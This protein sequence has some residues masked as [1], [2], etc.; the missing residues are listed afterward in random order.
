MDDAADSALI[1]LGWNA[2]LAA[3]WQL[4]GAPGEPRRVV[5]LDRGWSSV[6]GADGAIQRVRNL[7]ADVAAGDW[8]IVSDDG[9]RVD[10]VLQR[11][12]AFI[13][14]ASFEG[15]RAEAH[16][17][18]ANVDVAFLLH[19][20]T[21]P[22]N[23]RRI[24]RELVLAFD[25]GAKPV[26]VLTK[27]DAVEP[28]AAA[29]AAAFVEEIAAGVDLRLVSSRSGDGLGRITQY[30]ARG[31]TLAFLGA[32]GVGKSTLVN[33]LVGRDI[34]ATATVRTG[35][36]R[37]RH[38]TVAAELV[39]L[40]IGGWLI[41][42]PGLRAISLWSSGRGIERAFPDIFD[43][44]DHCRFRDCK[45]ED[46]PGCA[47]QSAISAGSLDPRRLISM[48]HL[49]AEELALEEEQR[50]KEKDKDKRHRKPRQSSLDDTADD[51]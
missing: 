42:T 47:V 19:A 35:D 32:S 8:V 33:A 16:T 37:G 6:L 41:D 10:H 2:E 20:L 4:L 3:S 30:A 15:A 7:G 49:V 12:S 39:S 27:L 29:A 13:R 23:P 28:V 5:R 26:L 34:Q 44:T 51:D 45:H 14:R 18:A 38:T 11:R 21:T 9:E 40:P 24:E 50:G 17:L 31:R 36:D 43:L 22:P 1:S 25:S 46:E 48:K